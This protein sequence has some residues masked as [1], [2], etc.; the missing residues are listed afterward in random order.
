MKIITLFAVTSLGCAAVHGAAADQAAK[1]AIDNPFDVVL[2]VPGDVPRGVRIIVKGE[3]DKSPFNE[4]HFIEQDHYQGLY[5]SHYHSRPYP[6]SAPVLAVLPA[7]TDKE[8]RPLWFDGPTGDQ[9]LGH[10]VADLFNAGQFA[11]LDQLF[12]DWNAQAERMA[13][14][15]WKLSV[16]YEALDQQFPVAANWDKIGTDILNWRQKTPKSRA[17]ALTE[18]IY[19]RAYAWNARG[20]G[21]ANSVTP[22]GWQLFR[23]RMTKAMAVLH[24]CKSFAASSPLWTRLAL[25]L[26]R[27]IQLPGRDLAIIFAEGVAAHP[28]FLP[29]YT[30]VAVTLSP[31]W[32]GNW[33]AVDSFV[34]EAVKDTPAEG[35]SLYARLYWSLFEREDPGFNLF[36]NTLATWPRMKQGFQDLARLYPHSAYNMNNFAA[37]ACMAGD[38]AT[39]QSVRFLLGKSVMPEVWPTN[40]SFD[41]CEHKFALEPL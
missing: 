9:I 2:N 16:F 26:A 10:L 18:V 23:E 3:D 25:D 14:G 7:A 4:A 37:A 38:K 1:P 8:G 19:W 13:D 17:A 21:Y 35:T 5:F 20:Q 27:E 6:L 32:G 24:D 33:Q 34:T 22:E 28:D 12:E 41:N 29:N 40:Y 15:R 31:R 30:S 11:D 36:S 39:F